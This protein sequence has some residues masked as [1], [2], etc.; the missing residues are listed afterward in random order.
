MQ[1]L[2]TLTGPSVSKIPDFNEHGTRWSSG[3]ERRSRW[4]MRSRNNHTLHVQLYVLRHSFL[5][6][7]MIKIPW[8]ANHFFQWRDGRLRGLSRG[9]A[10]AREGNAGELQERLL[11]SRRAARPRCSG[12]GGPSAGSCS[13]CSWRFP[14]RGAQSAPAQVA[15]L[16]TSCPSA[17]R[18][19]VTTSRL[20]FLGNA[21]L[22]GILAT[23]P[24][25]LL[26]SQPF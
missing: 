24:P 26:P 6:K 21:V 9:A 5:T 4:C 14:R 13:H 1:F 22:S 25:S 17:S 3:Q 20:R 7:K 12:G 15:I 18:Q 2:L 10:P 19:H 11:P 16:V 8:C 23:A